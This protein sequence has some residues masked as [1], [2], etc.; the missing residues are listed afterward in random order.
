MA[1][2]PHTAAA[3]AEV[4]LYVPMVPIALYLMVRNWKYRPRTAWYPPAVF[5]T[6]RLVGGIMT[7]IEQQNQ[8]NRGLIIATIVLLNIGLIPL[9]MAFLGYARLV[10]EHDFGDNRRVNLFLRLIKILV[11]VAA[12]LLGAAG[13][14]AGQPEF[15][16]TQSTLSKAAY[17]LF[18]VSLVAL[19]ASFIGLSR[20]QGRITPAHRIYVKWALVAAPPLCVRAAYGIIGVAVASGNNILTSSWSPLFGSATAFGLMALLPEYIVLCIYI[21]LSACHLR[22]GKQEEVVEGRTKHESSDMS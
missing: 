10:L 13:G 3:I 2:N 11:L 14:Y 1:I 21:Y 4:V 18:S 20:N 17:V 9:L 22:T 6:I 7:I 16:N 12:G 8:R 19:I 5:S 15:A